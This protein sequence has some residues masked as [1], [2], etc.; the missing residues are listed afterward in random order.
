MSMPA[1]NKRRVFSGH[2]WTESPTG[3]GFT[4]MG[5]ERGAVAWQIPISHDV[6]TAPVLAQDAVFFSTMDGVVSKVRAR[7]GRRLWQ[8]RVGA[9]TAPWVDG[10]RVL[11]ARRVRPP[12]GSRGAHEQQVVLDASTGRV[13]WEGEPVRARHLFGA[14]RARRLLAN[15]QGAWGGAQGDAHSHL[16]VRNVAEGWAY[17]GPRPTVIDGRAYLV[18]GDSIECRRL[19]DGQRLWSRRYAEDDGALAMSPPAVVGSQ[20]VLATVDGHVYG[21]DI[22]T[23]MTIW[24]YDVGQPIVY[25]P[26]VARGWIYVSTACGQVIGF[27]VAD[28]HLDGWH[29]WG[30]DA[31]HRGLSTDPRALEEPDPA[32]AT[33]E[34]EADRSGGEEETLGQ[35]ELRVVHPDDHRVERLALERMSFQ[36]QING[37]VASVTVRQTFANPNE[38]PLEAAYHFPL[39]SN[40]A[41]DSMILRAGEVSLLGRIAERNRAQVIYRA[42]RDAGHLAGLLEQQRPNLFTQRVANIPPGERVTVE[43]HYVQALEHR[44]G[45]YEIRFPMVAGSR[46]SDPTAQEPQGE[47]EQHTPG[48]RSADTVEVALTVD[49]GLPLIDIESPSHLVDVDFLAESRAHVLLAEQGSAPNR[50]F[51]LRYRIS[52][53]MPRAA[54]LSHADERGGFF[55]LMVQPGLELPREL[56]TARR[57]TFAVDTS[58]SMLGRPM[59]Q[60]RAMV[61]EALASLG[62]EDSFQIVTFSD[63]VRSFAEGPVRASDAQVVAGEQ[64]VDDMTALGTT[65]L[66]AGL[67]QT[68]ETPEAEDATLDMIVLLTDGNVTSEAEVLRMVHDRL[69]SRRLYPVALGP[70]PNL[71]L[72][73]RLAEVGRG[74]LLALSPGEASEVAAVE[75][76]ERVDNPQLTDL[77]IDWDELPVHSVYPRRLPDLFEGRPLLIHGRYDFAG[78]G[79]V[80]LAGRVGGRRWEEHIHVSLADRGLGDSESGLPQVWARAAVADLSN[81]LLLRED[82]DR[83]EAITGLG[84]AFG[85]VTRFTSFVAVDEAFLES[86][87]EDAL[88]QLHRNAQGDSFGYGGLGLVGTGRGGGGMDGGT[89]GLGN[90]GTI[91]HGSGGGSGTFYARAARAPSVRAGVATVRGS[92][93]REVILRQLRLHEASIRGAYERQ[94]LGNPDLE[95]RIVMQLSVSASGEIT[96]ATVESSTLASDQLERDLVAIFRSL[97]MPAVEGGGTVIIHYPI[98]FRPAEPDPHQPTRI[99]LELP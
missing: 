36:A 27:P 49:A 54:V 85:L 72:L 25:Q 22:D 5:I 95:G 68:L 58:S 87:G 26:S 40:A 7:D 20:M 45:E 82:P 88:G 91:G 80:V 18:V 84:L 51:V 67:R 70:S 98:V 1:A 55:T 4:A 81:G 74:D 93:S 12:R 6:I 92:L 65:S 42:A 23:G 37:F 15:Q 17:Q 21:L 2:L 13:V 28:E 97:R 86:L 29:M 3:Y 99:E 52:G 32:F 24:A 76:L 11:L 90:V 34:G 53:D 79:R 64:Y 8:R 83:Q 43:L 57:I 38:E 46:A 30:G 69:G 89:I 62:P 59:A 78:T 75:L 61:A 19:E 94:L 16:G 66:V 73:E 44:S 33:E 10:D 60:A 39:P 56:A 41:V 48:T 50:D 96:E 63:L 9:T 35:G 31:S 71:Y 14:G 47:I 77:Q